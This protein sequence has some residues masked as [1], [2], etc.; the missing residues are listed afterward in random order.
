ME[1]L[2]AVVL[3]AGEGCR[4]R[5]LT[6]SRPKPMLPAAT[7]PIL[8]CVLDELVEAGITDITVVVGYQRE[9]VQSHFGPTYRNVPLS[10]VRQRTRLG[11]GHA[12]RTVREAVDGSL[13]VVNGDQIVDRRIVGDVASAHRRTESIATLGLLH[14]RDV[15]DYGGILVDETELD[16]AGTVPVV[17]LVERPRDDR[18][19]RLNAGVYALEPEI[20]DAIAESEPRTGEHSLVDAISYLVAESEESLPLVR[21]VESDGLWVDATY[22]WDLLEVATELIDSGR[23]GDADTPGTRAIS[24]SASIHGSAVVREPVVVDDNCEIGPGAVVGP[25]ACLG[26]NVTVESGTVVERSV[27]DTDTRVRSNATVLECVAGQ[28]VEIGAGSTIPGGPGDVRVGDRVFED[29]NLGAL[30]ADRA[31]DDGDVTYAPGSVV[32]PNA[33]VCAGAT[34]RGTVAEATEVR[35]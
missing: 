22:P 18:E 31:R 19:Y 10:Y 17:E 7:T 25:Y 1:A 15:S 4:L 11:T 33:T 29:E 6:R 3:A 24:P 27:L 32:G 20:F 23:I 2:S 12:L 34:V 16:D 13:L 21:G 35:S 28:G 8:E 9:R 26:E 14:R 30:L 5:P